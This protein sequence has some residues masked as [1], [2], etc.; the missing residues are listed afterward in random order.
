MKERS[1][2]VFG[3]VLWKIAE[4]FAVQGVEFVISILLARLLLPEAYG[5]VA[6]VTA[7]IAFANVFVVSGFG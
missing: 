3:G 5:A 4:R 2:S 7:F 1:D 6:L